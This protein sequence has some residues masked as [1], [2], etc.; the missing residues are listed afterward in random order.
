MKKMKLILPLLLTI[1]ILSG[2]RGLTS[3][4]WEGNYPSDQPNTKWIS[5][6]G[7]IWFNGVSGYGK[8]TVNGETL[9][10]IVYTGWESDILIYRFDQI[11]Y[12]RKHDGF[13]FGDFIES[14][15]GC[16][17]WEDKFVATVGRSEYREEGKKLKFYRI[18]DLES[19]VVVYI[20]PEN[21]T[22]KEGN[23][24]EGLYFS[25]EPIPGADMAT[26][27]DLNTSG[28]YAVIQDDGR[29]LV[30]PIG[31]SMEDWIYYGADS[32]WTR[33]IETAITKFNERENGGNSN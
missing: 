4:W 8:M 12:S 24:D 7:S 10:V 25:T 3:Y 14:L 30:K 13:V 33:A 16:F 17:W 15:T 23:S 27:E 20:D 28:V 22:P 26:I 19:Q 21:I 29:V 9:D 1:T 31:G 2:C 18:N 6:D 5:E 32:I 11:K